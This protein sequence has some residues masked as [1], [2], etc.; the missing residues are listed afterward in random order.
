MTALCVCNH[1]SSIDKNFNS[2]TCFLCVIDLMLA[3]IHCQNVSS[4]LDVVY[5]NKVVLFVVEFI[6]VEYLFCFAH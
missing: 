1:C 4:L 6:Y 2:F 5:S 3:I